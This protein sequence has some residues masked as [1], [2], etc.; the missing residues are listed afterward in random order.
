MEDFIKISFYLEKE[1]SLYPPHPLMLPRPPFAEQCVDLV[2]E[3]D[4]GL[5]VPA[6]CVH[7]IGCQN[8]GVEDEKGVKIE[9]FRSLATVYTN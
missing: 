5:E 2:D 1:L 6:N 9:V 8:Y 7:D 3:D 4:G